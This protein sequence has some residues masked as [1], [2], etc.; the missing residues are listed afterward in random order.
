MSKDKK[1]FGA[2]C[3]IGGGK[4]EEQ[5]LK[6][7]SEEEVNDELG[8]GFL[9]GYRACLESQMFVEMNLYRT[10]ETFSYF[11]EGLELKWGMATEI[12]EENPGVFPSFFDKLFVERIRCVHAMRKKFAETLPEDMRE[13]A[14]SGIEEV[15]KKIVPQATAEIERSLM[16]DIPPTSLH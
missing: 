15:Y 10:K 14:I 12:M 8:E 4:M 16:L 1:T 7:L 5:E 11:L 6:Q 2:R 13:F 9:D 3:R